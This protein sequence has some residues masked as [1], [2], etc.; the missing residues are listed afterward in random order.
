ML[1]VTRK[2]DGKLIIGNEIEI[3]V[4][5]ISGN[6]VRLGIN[7]PTHISVYRSE[8]FEA[9]KKENPAAAVSQLPPK[10]SAA[11]ASSQTPGKSK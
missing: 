2:K 11:A 6:S 5:R 3:Q 9:I 1:V 10:S 8:V 7:A 4:L